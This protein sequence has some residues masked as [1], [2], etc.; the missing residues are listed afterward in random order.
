MAGAVLQPPPWL[1]HSFI[2]SSFHLNLPHVIYLF[3]FNFF[4]HWT[5]RWSFLV[6][7]LLSTGPTLSSLQATMVWNTIYERSF[8]LLIVL[9][10]ALVKIFGVSCMRDFFLLHKF[11]QVFTVSADSVYKLQCSSIVLFVPLPGTWNQMDWRILV[12][13]RIA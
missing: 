3:F 10:S 13:E 11:S 6:K 2:E 1:I 4:L 9:L 5:I 12:K 8:L 7:G